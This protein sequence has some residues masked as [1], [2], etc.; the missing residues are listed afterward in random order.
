MINWI[1]KYL[2]ISSL[3][4]STSVFAQVDPYIFNNFDTAE[5]ATDQ[6]ESAYWTYYDESTSAMNFSSLAWYDQLDLGNTSPVMDWS[7]SIVADLSWGEGFTGIMKF[8]D[9]AVDLSTHN[10]LS[11]K[12][13]NLAQPQ[14]ETVSFRVCLFDASEATSWTSRDDIEVWYAF[15]E[16]T[17]CVVNA[18]PEEGWVEY[19]IPLE[20]SGSSSGGTSYTLGFTKT[21]WVGIPGNDAFDKDQIAGLAFEVVN[22]VDDSTI[23]GEFLI[24]DIQAV[25]SEDI[26]GCTDINAC[27]YNPE[28]TVDDGSCY[29]CSDI[30]FRVDMALIDADPSQEIH[31]EGVY[32]AGGNFGQDGYLMED[33]DG[34][35]VWEY[36]LPLKVGDTFLYKFRN[37]PSYGTW[38]GFEPDAGLASGGCAM[39]QYN[40]RFIVVPDS[41][42]ILD[43]VCYGSCISCDDASFV[44]VTFS[45]NM[46]EEDTNPEGV[47]LAGG[48]FGGNPGFLMEDADGDDIWTLTKPVTPESNITYKF[49]NGPIDANW[50]GGWEEVPEDCS[51]GEF[52]D[53]QFQVGSVDVEVPTVCFG[54][55]MDCLGEYT[56]DITFNVDMT[57]VDGFDGSEQPYIFGSYNNW[58]NFSTQ[59]MLS[60]E[61][62]DNIYTGTILDFISTDS[63]TVLF[64]YGQTIESV[65]ADCGILDSDLGLNVRELPIMDS[66]G[67]SVLVLDAIAFGNCPLDNSPRV[68][69]QVDVSSMIDQWPAD[70]SLCAVGSFAGWNG[71][72][73]QLTDDDGD[74]IFTGLLTDLEDGIAYEYKFLV[75]EGWNDPNTES[76]APLGSECDFDPSDEFNNYGF[77]ASEGLTPLDL[78]VHPWNECPQL[79]S[80]DDFGYLVPDN[81]TYMAY[82]NPFNPTINIDYA[83]PSQELVNLSIINLLGQKVRTLANDIQEPG[84]YSFK[85]DGKDINGIDLQSGI[86]FAVISR[87]SGQNIVKITYL[88]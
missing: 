53:R 65:P 39:G 51:V 66:E 80:N 24:E 26:L 40:D 27:N 44:N 69:F 49:V 23:N 11:F 67:D 31:P 71:C 3:M 8:Y 17:E 25:Y 81:F 70:F 4:A 68:Y 62:G 52:N 86:Y 60:D 41:D 72:G 36:T 33:A 43:A 13:Y 59:T 47:W 77:I 63:V 35:N 48:N 32:L 54:G 55:C 84:N 58:D 29:E 87:N 6:G 5:H 15:F 38:D 78:G 83:L 20:G 50:S 79:L 7:Y 19:K 61:D 75:N 2:I 10:Y 88:K 16:G 46:Q 12:V 18:S 22:R 56:V 82:P 45:V 37:T 14:N 85:W 76:G 9:Q 34:D 42:S 1:K 74:N 21:G 28:A 57:N 30:T 64:G 73:L